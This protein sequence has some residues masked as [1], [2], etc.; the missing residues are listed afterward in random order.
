MPGD[1]VVQIG[2]VGEHVV[3]NQ[4]VGLRIAGQRFAPPPRRRTRRSVGM[5]LLKRDLRDV[6]RRLDAEHRDLRW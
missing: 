4:E 2:H 1:E 6:G 3:C 5:P